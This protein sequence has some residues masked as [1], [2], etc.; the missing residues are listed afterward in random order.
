MT[1]RE[2]ARE[3]VRQLM[4]TWDKK[5]SSAELADAV[6]DIYEPLLR[7]AH[8]AIR[9]EQANAS[10]HFPPNP[11]EARKLIDAW[12]NVGGTLHRI[13]EALGVLDR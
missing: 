3:A 5:S 12:Y 11:V 8:L 7:E 9:A 1:A 10:D 4:W 6:C 2:Q 13:E